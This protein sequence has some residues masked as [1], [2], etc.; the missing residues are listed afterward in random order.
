MISKYSTMPRIVVCSAI[1]GAMAFGLFG[2]AKK[3]A[4]QADATTDE[5]VTEEVAG[6]PESMPAATGI[7]VAEIGEGDAMQRV[8]VVLN[9]DYTAVVTVEYMNEQPAM[10]QNGNWAMGEMDGAV[11]F[12][13]GSGENTMTMPMMVVEE[14]LHMAGD[15]ASAMGVEEIVLMKQVPDA[16]AEE[17]HEGH[18][19]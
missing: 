17:S 19:H 13:Y 10:T 12:M 15:M 16:S 3:D 7:Y 2:C 14:N 4:D 9:D 8:T 18:N 1:V 6:M 5:M 11:N